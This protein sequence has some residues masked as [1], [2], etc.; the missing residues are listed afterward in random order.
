MRYRLSPTEIEG[1]GS[2]QRLRLARNDLAIGADG[3]VAAEPTQQ[4]EVIECGLV[5]RSVGYR[6]QPIA[7]L[8]FDGATRR[9]PP[10]HGRVV[11]D[12]TNEPVPG[13]YA[14]GGFMRGPTGFIGTN[15]QD[16]PGTA[17]YRR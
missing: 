14:T 3:T 10:R 17:A 7:G 9:V 11:R 1:T 16:A 15:E 12:D 5:L 8:P 4:Q 13:V 6:A 2:V